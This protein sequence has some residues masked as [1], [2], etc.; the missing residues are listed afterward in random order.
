[1]EN[2]MEFN[3]VAAE[4]IAAGD[5]LAVYAAGSTATERQVKKIASGLYNAIIGVSLKDVNAG[6]A[7]TFSGIKTGRIV[8]I[9]VGGACT[10]GGHLD[11]TSAGAISTAGTAGNMKLPFIALEAATA[12]GD[13]IACACVVNELPVIEADEPEPAPET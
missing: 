5:V 6:E 8:N 4:K 7:V 1:M 13:V 9:K 2:L 10:L 3:W 12:A 11:V